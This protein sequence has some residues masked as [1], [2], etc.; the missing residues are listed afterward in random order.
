MKILKWTVGLGLGLAATA[1]NAQAGFDSGSDGSYGPIYLTIPALT[2]ASPSP[3]AG[4]LSG[5]IPAFG[6]GASTSFL[7]YPASGN[8]RLIRFYAE[9]PQGCTATGGIPAGTFSNSIA[10]IE[11]GN[12]QFSEKIINAQAAGAT[13]VYIFNDSS[14]IPTNL[15]GGSA[16]IPSAFLSRADG[17]ALRD[18]IVGNGATQT[19]VNT[20]NRAGTQTLQVPA[21]GIFH[22]TEVYVQWGTSLRFTCNAK[23]TPVYLLSIGKVTVRGTISVDAPSATRSPFVSPGGCGGFAGGAGGLIGQ[24]PPGD[25]YGPGAGRGAQTGVTGSA[26]HGT[27]SSGSSP[28]NGLVY[29][30]QLL[31]PPVGGSGG[32]GREDLQGNGGGGALVISSNSRIEIRDFSPGTA[33]ISASAGVTSSTGQGSGG[34]IRLVAPIVDGDGILSVSGGGGGATAGSGGTGRI[35]VDTIDRSGLLLNLGT[36]PRTVGSFMQIFPPNVPELH[37]VNVAGTAIPVGS[38]PVNVLLPIGSPAS[39]GITLRGI[40]FTGTVPVRVVLT[41]DSGPSVTVDGTLAMGGQN[42]A[43][44]TL[45]AEV[46]ANV[47]MNVSAWVRNQ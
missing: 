47:T 13:T 24:F 11:R 40:G 26:A 42:S 15:S 27:A 36:G 32:G 35:R 25:G 28:L 4:S 22:A 9:N 21:D 2:I 30:G 10:L 31:V 23:N 44:V 1:A 20:V 43:E 16:P 5:T 38:G 45:Q 39:Q 6:M 46:P 14:E 8:N 33:R 34:S 3:P 7:N 29:G 17:R 12:C 19:L 41:P 18:F 37:I